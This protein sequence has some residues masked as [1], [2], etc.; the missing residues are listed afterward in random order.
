MELWRSGGL[1]DGTISVYLSWVRRFRQRWSRQGTDDLT[2][3]TRAHVREFASSYTGPRR[4]AR[5]KQS[6]RRGAY[7][8]LH[9]WACA[10]QLMGLHVPPWRPASTPRRWPP[11][12]TA[13]A[14]YRRSHRGVASATLARDMAVCTEFLGT[15]KSRR[16]KI[17]MVAVRDI[18]RFVDQLS[19]RLSRRTTAGLCSSLRCFLRFLQ[20]TG[21]IHRD[22]A[23]CVVAP[24]FR[25]DEQ[26][27]R[28]LPWHAVRRI[29][30]AIPRVRLVGCRDYA[31]FMLMACYG[32][33]AAEVVRLRLEDV[34][35]RAQ[36]LRARRPKTDVPLDLPLLPAV[37]KAIALYL[38]VRPSYVKSR[39]IF[40]TVA[41]PHRPITSAV[42]RH[43]TTKYARAAGIVATRIGAH[44]FRH[45]HATRQIDAGAQPKVVSDILG[46]RR[47]S[48]TSVYVRVAIRRLRGVALPVPR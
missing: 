22:L 8:A 42:L 9:A 12:L 6:T 36:V 17:A 37:A 1:R 5:V 24:R 10:L 21:R 45:S 29:L 44:V 43:Q 2:R 26:P 47:P 32:F 15:L 33:G 7:D 19:A 48:S 3:L 16:R 4:G 25:A 41:L 34:D 20:V 30:R 40:V 11:L 27:P 38:R 39:E 46:H 23:S 35:W 18:D 31:M 14:R 13:Y 28:A